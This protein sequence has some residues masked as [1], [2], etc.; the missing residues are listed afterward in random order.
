MNNNSESISVTTSYTSYALD[1]KKKVEDFFYDNLSLPYK[2]LP[3]HSLEQSPCYPIT[4][5][6][7]KRGTYYCKLHRKESE[8]IHLESVEHHCK[9]KDPDVHKKEI[10]YK[11]SLIQK[12]NVTET[13]DKNK[14][15]AQFVE[16][17]GID[18]AINEL[19][20]EI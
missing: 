9:Y 19:W 11:L 8:N 7:H 15:I 5:I 13:E 17:S 16:E 4:G 14:I 6:N 2:P 20:S 12:D 10:I 1:S 3:P 18:D